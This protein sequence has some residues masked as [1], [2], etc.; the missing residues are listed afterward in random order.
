MNEGTMRIAKA[1]C[2]PI[3]VAGLTA[4]V[5]NP[6]TP[7][8]PDTYRADG[9]RPP[10]PGTTLTLLPQQ[11]TQFDEFREGV[12]Q[13]HRQVQKQLASAGYRV[14][15]LN[16]DDYI[17]RWK[18]EA[19]AVGGVY[20]TE[21]GE[22]KGKEY[23]EALSTLIRK[24]CAETNCAMLIDA[25]LVVRPAEVDG[26]NVLWDG[27]KKFSDG[28]VP[29]GAELSDRTYGISVEISA[30]LPDGNLAFR[31]YGGATLPPQYELSELQSFSRK[32]VVWNDSD[33]AA[34]LRIALQPLQEKSPIPVPGAL[35]AP[36][37]K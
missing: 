11:E 27:Q 25:R 37:A 21:S 17:R 9:F 12:E 34:G 6:S 7:Q 28:P 29:P 16:K 33:L 14:V 5:S 36:V 2:A 18:Q 13:L 8:A 26:R 3:L 4:C 10:P 32:P 1:L 23:M 24:S 20:H 31:T 35:P 19:N 22:F 30:I 15:A